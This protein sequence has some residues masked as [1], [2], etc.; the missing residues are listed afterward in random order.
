MPKLIMLVGLPACGKTSL[1]DLIKADVIL[2]TDNFIEGRAEQQ[3]KTYNELFQ[4]QIDNAKKW[5]EMGLK[6]GIETSKDIVWDQTNLTA[7]T[8]KT[9]LA[10]IP[11]YYEK[12]C[13]FI[14]TDFETVLSRN[15]ERRALGRNIPTRVLF[16]MK[17]SLEIPTEEEGFDKIY[18]FK[19]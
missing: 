7:K 19:N 2:S 4:S 9:K 1:R 10:K 12:V 18:T 8:R 5:L 16:Q 17:D 11:D 15:Q 3:G 13:I 14:D 6:F